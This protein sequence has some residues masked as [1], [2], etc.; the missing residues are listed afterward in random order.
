MRH[1]AL[2]LLLAAAVA[3][4]AAQTALQLGWELKEDVFT[5]PSG[6]NA[7]RVAF[8][9]T[10]G[11][12]EPLPARGWAIYFN[13]LHEPRPGSVKGGV[14]IERVTGG[15]Q[16]IV[17]GPGFAGLAPGASAQIEYL[18]H[19]LV[20][21]SFAPVG[22]YVV[23]DDAPDRGIALRYTAV[24]FERPP[25]GPGRDPR[26]V[27]PQRQ[28]ELDRAVRDLPL[29]TLPPVLPTPVLVERREGRLGLAAMPPV[30]GAP[31]LEREA[32]FAAEYLRPHLPRRAGKAAPV[33]FRLETGTVEGQGSPEAYE[34]VIDPVQ[35]V[36]VVGNSP[37]GV[38]Y[39]L[40][41]LRGM[42]PVPATGKGLSLPALRIV[43][44]PRFGYRGF[45]LDVAR[46]FHPRDEVL[47]VLDLMA[48]YKL[49]VFHFH[50]TEDEG[51]RLE[52]PSLPELTS[53]GARRGH[54]LD[55]RLF[56]P[57]AWGS[58]PDVDRP[59]GSP[60]TTPGRTTSRSSGTPRRGTS[61]SC[62]SWRCRA[63]PAPRSRRWRPATARSSPGATRKGRG[64]TCS[65]TRR[66][67][68]STPRPSSTTTTS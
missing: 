40:Q 25:Q 56:L 64:A 5:G 6:P 35:G 51:W 30:T 58:G 1:A 66:T 28:Y 49:N 26:L 68:R 16:R 2:F 19:L 42:L 39:G 44:A 10:N 52:M 37:A 38:F 15:L 48:R 8:T 22:P 20:N 32:V 13:S 57:P 63:T 47:R 36:R 59:W 62:P 31:G 7:A 4:V 65:A 27:T 33:P 18:T 34:L 45:M 9:L 61:R 60:A 14:A 29:E 41:S 17:P 23:F 46:N 54:T 53:V 11:G 43:D 12:A 21:N 55:S 24:P 50:L 67:A 3:P